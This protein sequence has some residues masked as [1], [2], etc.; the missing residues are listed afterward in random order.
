M[1]YR[2]HLY[3]HEKYDMIC[4]KGLKEDYYLAT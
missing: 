4:L 1:L 3:S 2:V